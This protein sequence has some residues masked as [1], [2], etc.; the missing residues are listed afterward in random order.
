MKKKGVIVR[1]I[2]FWAIGIFVVLLIIYIIAGP[3]KLLAKL[4]EAIFYFGK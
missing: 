4:K 2:I 3:D 1:P